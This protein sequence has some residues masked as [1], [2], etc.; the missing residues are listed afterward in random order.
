M[1]SV[2]PLIMAGGSG[3]RLWPLSETNKP[4]QYHL[5]LNNQMLLTQTLNRCSSETFC[6]PIISTNI[7]HK[8]FIEEI[9]KNQF[10]KVIYESVGKNTAASILLSCLIENDPSKCMLVLPSDHYIPDEEYFNDTIENALEY[11]NEFNVITFGVKP[12]YLSTQYGYIHTPVTHEV[13]PVESFH[14]KPDILTAKRMIDSGEYLW[15]SGIFLFNISKLL[16]LVREINPSLINVLS[17]IASSLKNNTRELIVNSDL[18]SKL[19]SESFDIAVMEKITGIGCYRYEKY[20][21]D[22]GDWKRIAEN[23]SS[24]LLIDSENSF[25]KSYDHDHDVVGIGLKDIICIVANNK[26][27]CIDK[28]RS[29]DIKNI[30]SK[31]NEISSFS[32]KK[33]YRPWGWYESLLKLPNYQIKILHVNPKSELSLQSH[34][35]RSEHWIVLE[36]NAHVQR[37]RDIFNLKKDESIY[38]DKKEKHKLCNKCTEP[39]KIIEVQIGDYLEEDDIVRYDNMCNRDY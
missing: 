5:I 19:E 39:L 14:E 31:Y 38:L 30:L 27:L 2:I 34:D 35:R 32:S 9:D 18:W 28:S 24:D 16:D 6:E 29:S 4:K 33:E 12:T 15:N 17:R 11:I 8:P 23:S 37:N 10:S 36:G 22:L 7:L 21:S 3:T 20:W 25:V 26:T 1:S 13:G